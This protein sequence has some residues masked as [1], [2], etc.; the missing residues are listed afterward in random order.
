MHRDRAAEIPGPFDAHPHHLVTLEPVDEWAKPRSVIGNLAA[1]DKPA[2]V[3]DDCDGEGVLW[4]SIP[5]IILGH[6]PFDATAGPAMRKHSGDYEYFR[7]Y[8]APSLI[9]AS[10]PTITATGRSSHRPEGGSSLAGS[11]R[12]SR[13]GDVA[14]P[15]HRRSKPSIPECIRCNRLRSSSRCTG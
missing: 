5:A 6:L 2:G 8:V 13:P 4:V 15:A 14:S 12:S 7:V 11:I 9:W 1:G 10:S 3:V